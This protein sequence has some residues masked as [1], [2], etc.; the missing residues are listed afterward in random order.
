MSSTN[1]P[2]ADEQVLEPD[3]FAAE[4]FWEKHRGSLLAGAAAVVLAVGGSAIW[5][6]SAHNLILA[7][8][9][10]FAEAKNPEA[11]REV[12]AKYPHSPQAADAYFLLAES[13]REQGSLAES[14][15]SLEKFLMNFPGHS[16]AG[17]ARL[18][19]AENAELAGKS[20]EALTMLREV[21]SKDAGSYAAPF[22][23]LLEG[24]ISLRE[25]RLEEARKIFSN[26]ISTYAQ[27][28]VAR[29]AG[30]Q[31]D[32]ITSLIPPAAAS[33]KTLQ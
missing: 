7:A 6:I 3:S 27:S 33:G 25:G 12:I 9:V 32:E 30:A 18:G 16:L 4:L 22:A 10:F 2:S 8:E 15:A 17:G 1:Q 29:V 21:Q 31:L 26:L 11:W 28:P 13:Q 19:L 20:A 5:F 24:R 14:T 23:A